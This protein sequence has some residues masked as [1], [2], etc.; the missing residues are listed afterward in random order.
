VI[1]PRVIFCSRVQRAVLFAR[2]VGFVCRGKTAAQT[3]Q[4]A[5]QTKQHATQT[6]QHATQTKQHAPNRLDSARSSQVPSMRLIQQALTY[7]KEL[8][9]IV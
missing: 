1:V 6:K 7:A 5:T 4:H 8:E 3:K 9:R 2:R